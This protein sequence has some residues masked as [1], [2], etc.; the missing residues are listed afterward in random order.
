MSKKPTH[1]GYQVTKAGKTTF[2]NRIGASF[3]VIRPG[4]TE[5]RKAIV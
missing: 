4:D 1:T 3:L 2:R 5:V